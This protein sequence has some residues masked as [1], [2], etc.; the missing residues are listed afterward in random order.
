MR[1]WVF[2]D[3]VVMAKKYLCEIVECLS[4]IKLFAFILA[5]KLHSVS[6]VSPWLW[7]CGLPGALPNLRLV[8]ET[9]T[10]KVLPPLRLRA[11]IPEATATSFSQFDRQPDS[12]LESRRAIFWHNCHPRTID[13]TASTDME[14]EHK[15]IVSPFLTFLP[16]FYCNAHDNVSQ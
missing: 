12:R 5:P 13:A 4:E 9:G 7:V 8:Y 3:H 14:T 10:A 16:S 6:G 15:M 2:L 1:I 11:T